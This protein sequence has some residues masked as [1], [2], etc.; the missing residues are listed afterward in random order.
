MSHGFMVRPV[1][2]ANELTLV[3]LRC[4]VCSQLWSEQGV[5]FFSTPT[6]P[7]VP[8]ACPECGQ[9]G[10]VLPPATAGVRTPRRFRAPRPH[11]QA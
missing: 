1:W 9:R 2:T 3:Q 5:R 11:A 8:I 6:F 4:N 10:N 7:T